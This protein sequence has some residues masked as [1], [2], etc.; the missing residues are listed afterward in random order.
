MEKK[1]YNMPGKLQE[2]RQKLVDKIIENMNN[3]YVL[4]P[5]EWNKISKLPYNP[6]TFVHYKAGNIMRL[7]VSSIES[8]FTDPRWCTYK[9][10]QKMGWNVKKGAK[11]TL[12]E[13]WIFTEEKIVEDEKTG[14]KRKEVVTLKRPKCNFFYV[15]NAEQIHGIPE[16]ETK[17]KI[18]NQDDYLDTA[19]EMK[20]ISEC[21]I[22]E[23]GNEAYYSIKDDKIFIPP[24]EQ[25]INTESFLATMLHEMAHSTGAENRLGRD[26]TGSFGSESYAKEE[27]RAELSSVFIQSDLELPPTAERLQNNSNYLL[28]WIK[29]LQDDPNELFRACRDAEKACEYIMENYRELEQMQS[30]QQDMAYKESI[31]SD[32]NR[33]GNPE[34]YHFFYSP[35]ERKQME[36][37]LS[38][39][40]GYKQ[41]WGSDAQG[42]NG[43]TWVIYRDTTD[44]PKYLQHYALEQEIAT[45]NTVTNTLGK[46][47]ESGENPEK[48][49]QT[50]EPKRICKELKKMGCQPSKQLVKNIE[51]LQ[52]QTGKKFS[53]E[54]L[55]NL[56][57]K[58]FSDPNN[59][60]LAV[61]IT[62]T[63]QELIPLP[64]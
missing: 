33:F 38:D 57:P 47:N 55:N 25:F 3:G 28:S 21:P 22:I 50:T 11:G 58:D 2:N 7:L 56:N 61:F 18:R 29:V 53:A 49:N 42:L 6:V 9:Q 39:H 16:L 48:T 4:L 8:G 27:L 60:K 1:S 59:R 14:E 12:L 20:L 23:E 13:K 19:N 40:P 24:N 26:M 5:P 36:E 34:F 52:K 62:N 41:I 31:Q 44:L 54:Q 45:K 43:D 15:F 63:L 51:Q 30:Q 17:P 35:Y 32:S 37:Y 10:A 46:D 64:G